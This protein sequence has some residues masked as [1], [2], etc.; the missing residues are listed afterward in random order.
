[1]CLQ[2]AV[3]VDDEVVVFEFPLD[4]DLTVHH[5]AQNHVTAIVVDHLHGEFPALG[6]RDSV[7]CPRSALTD[8]RKDFVVDSLD[9]Y[10]VVQKHLS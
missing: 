5:F 10:V 1:M 6:I 3:D 4:V 9:F 2:A 7:D 8:L